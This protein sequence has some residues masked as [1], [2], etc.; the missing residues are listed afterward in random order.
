MCELQLKLE[1]TTGITATIYFV[2]CICELVNSHIPANS[3]AVKI[4]IKNES[5]TQYHKGSDC[6]VLVNPVGQADRTDPVFF[7]DFPNIQ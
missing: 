4:K 7:N 6:L 3:K 5:V 2:T 1:W